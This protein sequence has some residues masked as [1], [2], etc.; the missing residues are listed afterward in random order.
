VTDLL[1]DLLNP[2][3]PLG[4]A[5]YSLLV[6]FLTLGGVLG[7]SRLDAV[8]KRRQPPLMDLASLGFL[9]R[10]AQLL[11]VGVG[12][13]VY[14]HLVPELERLSHLLLAGVSVASIVLG[15]AAQST[16]RDLVSGFTVVLHR[17]FQTGDWLQVVAP[18]GIE[19]AQVE[20]LTLGF[21]ILRCADGRRLVYPNSLIANQ[22]LVRLPAASERSLLVLSVT[23]AADSDPDQARTILSDALASAEGVDEVVEVRVTALDADRMTLEASAWCKGP[24]GQERIEPQLLGRLKARLLAAGIRSLGWSSAKSAAAYGDAGAGG[25]HRAR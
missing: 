8:L 6:A 22:T 4:L 13:T 24:F 14:A 7:L 16:L 10:C 25:R 19:T 2:S 11:V 21:T 5:F 9:T 23:L 15:L 1:R 18:T 20:D 12:A 17:P 3:T